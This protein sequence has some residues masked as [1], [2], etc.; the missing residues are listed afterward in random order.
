MRHV[1]S[2]QSTMDLQCVACNISCADCDS[3]VQHQLARHQR[4][5]KKD[6]QCKVCHKGFAGFRTLHRHWTKTHQEEFGD[7]LVKNLKL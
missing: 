5:A 7:C 1:F 2:E 4:A 3:L 6:W